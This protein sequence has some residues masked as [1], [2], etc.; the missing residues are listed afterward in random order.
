M[1][2]IGNA[3]RAA[4]R[5]ADCIHNQ[6][7]RTP[8]A[9]VFLL[10]DFNHCKPELVLPGFYQ[11]VK[12]STRKENVLDKRFGNI[13]SAYKAKALPPLANSGHSTVF[14]MP[15]Y[16]T[17]LKSSKP[18]EKTALLWT[19]DNIETLSGCFLSTDWSIFHNQDLNKA[20]VSLTDYIAFCM[21]N[22]VE[23]KIIWLC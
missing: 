5:L 19:E 12:C 17:L 11:Y 9:P 22:V 18:Q 2:P 23:K 16:K 15:T 20:V 4:K 13:N 10:G 21:D 1:P 14:L 8:G 6:S 3:Q 7:Q